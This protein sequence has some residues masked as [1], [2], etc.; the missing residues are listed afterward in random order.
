M[1]ETKHVTNCSNIKT[2]LERLI[3]A[4]ETSEIDQTDSIDILC[5]LDKVSKKAKGYV[6]KAKKALPLEVGQELKGNIGKVKKSLT[7]NWEYPPETVRKE[8]NDADFYR[9]VKVN[10]KN[11][12]TFLAKNRM[13]EIRENAGT[14]ERFHFET[15]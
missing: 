4:L 15:I 2:Y 10:A 14:T 13:E 12:Q 8:L 1:V 9:S 7:Q 6:D 5:M 3:T 11:L